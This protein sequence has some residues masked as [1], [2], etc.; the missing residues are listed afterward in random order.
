MRQTRG[1][2]PRFGWASGVLLAVA[3]VACEGRAPQPGVADKRP[4]SGPK[5]DLFDLSGGLPEKAASSLLSLSSAPTFDEFLARAGRSLKDDETRGVFVSWN[6]KLGLARAWEAGTALGA[7]RSAGKKV[8]CHAH[9]YDNASLLGAALGCDRIVVSPAGEVEAIG[10]AAQVVYLRKFLVEELKLSI[11]ILQVGKFKG[12]EEPLTRDGPSEEAR[13]SLQGVLESFR[14]SWLEGV[15][16][17]RG[18]QVAAALER[19]PFAPNEGKVQ[20]LVDAVGYA[21]DVL[22]ELEDAV[23]ARRE[24]V[25]LGKH[26]SGLSSGDADLGVLV[27]ALGGD[28]ADRGPVALVKA[29]GSIA[30]ASG[31]GGL[32]GGSAGIT[33]REL[34]KTVR[35]LARDST[36][37][38]VV[39]RIDSPGGSALAS[40]LLWHELMKLREKKPVVISVGEMAASG[41][42][43]LASTGSWIVADAVSLVGSIGVVG[44]KI[45]IGPALERWG[46]HAETFPANPDDPGAA[47]RAAYLSPLVAWDAPTKER[48]YA[49][50]KGVYDLF[51]ARAAEGRKVPVEVIAASAEGRVWSGVQGKERGLVDEI[52][53]L[54]RAVEKA[55]ELANLPPDAKLRRIDER[56]AWLEA[57]GNGEGSAARAAAAAASLALRQELASQLA[58]PGFEELAEQ[59]LGVAAGLVLPL[60]AGEHALCIAPYSVRIR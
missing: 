36:V 12:A 1:S 3:C 15:R 29:V 11:D 14:A 25:A 44:G 57:L 24:E 30:M 6:G 56:P 10:L 22:R 19:G 23:Q 39:L 41:G 43:Y 35:K 37:K 31:E 51:L 32:L 28:D 7:L 60:A 52:G 13:A 59:P 9:G 42:Y 18:E 47:A 21:D 17:A 55:R 40:D 26:P 46:I 8:Y 54:S 2:T 58:M 45:G 4:T 34:G 20:G 49:S 38:A 27:Q 50:M 53:G 33:E 5:V 16:G 48:V